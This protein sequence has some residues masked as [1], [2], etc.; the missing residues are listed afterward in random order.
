MLKLTDINR[1][2]G[3]FALTGINLDITEGQYYVLLGRSGSGKTQLL[4]LIAGL[5]HPDSGNIFLDGENITKK[6]IQE[7]KIGIVFQDYAIFPHMTVFGNITYP[8]KAKKA[9]E[10]EIK[11]K[12]VK[13]AREMNISHLLDRTT[14]KLSSGELQ[15]IALARTLITSPRLLL[16]DEPLA[17]LDA[18]LKDDMKRVLRK[19]NKAGQTII[20]VTHDYRDAISLANKVGVIHNGRIIQEGPVDEVFNKPVN[21]FVARYA[22]LRNF[23]RIKIISENG[24]FKGITNNNLEFKLCGDIKQ[25]DCLVILKSEDILLSRT[26]PEDLSLNFFKSR[27]EEIIPSEYGMELILNAGDIFYANISKIEFQRL[28]VDEN[29]E[30]WISFPIGAAIVINGQSE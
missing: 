23:F 5:E 10:K 11:E 18:S 1:R 19:I 21:R 26:K 7:R 14:E 29:E 25:D 16:L 2:L 8:L 17:S 30:I 27:V 9:D 20:H 15:R 3:D 28:S 22:G 24:I 4:E 12:V 6:K 13:I